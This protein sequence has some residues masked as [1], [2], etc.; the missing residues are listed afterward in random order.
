M[1]FTFHPTSI[2]DVIRVQPQV[3]GDDR[4]FF[5]ETYKSSD[6]AT[7]GIDARFVQD[8]HSRSVRGV[9]R[10]LHYQKPPA[11]QAK[12][13]RVIRGRIRDVAVDLREN[14]ETFGQWVAT[15][16]SADNLGMLYMPEGFAHGFAVLSEVA[17]VEY[18]V[19]S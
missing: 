4:G 1:P 10:G 5:L 11:A 7:G 17:E 9:L 2:P 15:D 13:V 14:A 3:F 19:T 8:N 18:K 16:L 6:F 12:L